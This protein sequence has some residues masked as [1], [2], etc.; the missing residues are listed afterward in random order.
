[1]A[2]QRA[3]LHEEK[4]L[5]KKRQWRCRAMAF[6]E[7]AGAKSWPRFKSACQ[8]RASCP[9]GQ[10]TEGLQWLGWL[11]RTEDNEGQLI[12]RSISV[13]YLPMYGK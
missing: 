7:D 11:C 5:Q 13:H 1:M 3:V 2:Q 10:Q 12:S 4:T 6:V 9:T 8:L